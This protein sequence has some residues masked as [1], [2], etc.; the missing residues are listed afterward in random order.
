MTNKLTVP[1]ELIHR[2][3]DAIEQVG[4]QDKFIDYT[5][6]RAVKQDLRTALYDPVPPAGGEPEVLAAMLRYRASNTNNGQFHW[7]DWSEWRE[8]STAYAESKID[9][10]RGSKEAEF[11]VIEL[12]DRAHV[13]RL[14]AEVDRLK[15]RLADSNAIANL[16]ATNLEEFKEDHRSELTK[17]LDRVY[18]LEHAIFHALDDSGDTEDAQAMTITR[19]DFD[20]LDALLPED[21]EHRSEADNPT[22]AERVEQLNQEI[23]TLLA[24]DEVHCTG[25]VDYDPPTR[26]HDKGD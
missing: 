8:V 16:A 3:I 20:K 11:Q 5:F 26:P 9:Q 18:E 6:V 12:V 10:S 15:D 24:E 4:Y 13:T 19:L 23:A 17:A 1:S 7:G 22:R 2:A 25:H 14:Q 21:W